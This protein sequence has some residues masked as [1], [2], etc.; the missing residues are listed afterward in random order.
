M[1]FE[2]DGTLDEKWSIHTDLDFLAKSYESMWRS[3]NGASIFITGG[4]GT[5]GKWIIES[6]CH[7]NRLFD[8]EINVTVLTRQPDR[9][10]NLASDLNA[11]RFVNFHQGNVVD[12][13]WPKLGFS[14][15]IHG[16]ATN[17]S[18]SSIVYPLDTFTS[19]VNGTRSVLEM[20]SQVGVSKFLFLSSGAV[21]GPQP[22]EMVY[23]EERYLGGP[24]PTKSNFAYGEAKRSAEI[25][26]SM[27]AEQFEFEA[28]IARIFAVVG[29]GMPLDQNFAI[30]NFI[31]DCL[32]GRE[33]IINGSGKPVRSYLYLAD[34]AYWLLLILTSGRSGEA[35]NV[36]SDVEVSLLELA[37]VVARVIGGGKV[38]KLGRDDVGPNPGRYIPSISKVRTELGARK[39][40][41]LEEGVARTA[42][43]NRRDAGTEGK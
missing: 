36:G 34:V 27:F 31:G 16:A 3:L 23:L 2:G 5:I 13:K 6:I 1:L 22:P 33:I 35:Y 4:S 7:A 25:L 10:L 42:A 43:W 17:S 19:I 11:S 41:S 38:R 20:A 39:R 9:V 32:S 12:F 21:Y 30:G 24:D 18:K 14:H 8:L 40:F 26:C 29:P 15:V 37:E 28:M